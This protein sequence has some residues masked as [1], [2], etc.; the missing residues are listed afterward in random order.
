M[1]SCVKSF[2]GLNSTNHLKKLYLCC[3]TRYFRFRVGLNNDQPSVSYYD[4]ELLKDLDTQNYLTLSLYQTDTVENGKITGQR[5]LS[6]C[7]TL[8]EVFGIIYNSFLLNFN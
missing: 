4:Y 2:P 8:F 7:Y 1:L 6:I 5:I 3:W